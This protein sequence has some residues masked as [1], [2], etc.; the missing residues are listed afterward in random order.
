MIAGAVCA[1][2]PWPVVYLVKY[3]CAKNV[4]DFGS[5]NAWK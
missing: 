4:V 3:L 1:W 5:T 2:I